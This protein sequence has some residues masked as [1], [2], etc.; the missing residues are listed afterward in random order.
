MAKPPHAQWT[1]DNL[2]QIAHLLYPFDVS[3]QRSGDALL[4]TGHDGMEIELLPGD[5]LI[6]EDDKLGVVRTPVK[7]DAPEKV[8]VPCCWCRKPTVAYK[9]I[10]D[11]PETIGIV[12]SDSCYEAYS[13]QVK[14][15]V[16]EESQFN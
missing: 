13:A 14:A 15:V 2:N 4:I 16:G 10:A 8:T 12:C 11:S 9:D 3:I 5:S 1:C 7:R 6:V